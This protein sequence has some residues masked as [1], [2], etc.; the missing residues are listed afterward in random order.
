MVNKFYVASII[1]LFVLG[2]FFILG[3][4]SPNVIAQFPNSFK[5]G[6][7]ISGDVTITI[8]QGDSI[9]A[10]TPILIA[11]SSS[12][13]GVLEANT[14]TFKEFTS[15]S[16]DLPIETQKEG[17][18]YYE[19]PGKYSVDISKVIDY[20]FID[21]GNYELT[22]VIFALDISQNLPIEVN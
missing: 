12:N 20:K 4:K 18:I 3:W 7:K 6:D 9:S 16:K 13:G 21:K 10:D 17:K 19:T 5:V 11:L 14:M 2:T 8:E 15:Y 22:F 1:L